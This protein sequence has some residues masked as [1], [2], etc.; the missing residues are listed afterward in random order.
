MRISLYF[1]FLLLVLLPSCR[2]MMKGTI[3]KVPEPYVQLKDGKM[4]QASEVFDQ[5][6]IHKEGHIGKIP[7]ESTI[8]KPRLVAGDSAFK[9]HTVASFSDGWRSFANVGRNNFVFRMGDGKI[10]SYISLF[11]R[12]GEGHSEQTFQFSADFSGPGVKDF[13]CFQRPVS[14][15]AVIRP[16]ARFYV[17]SSNEGVVKKLNY[18]NLRKMI[19][20]TAVSYNYLNRYKWT[21]IITAIGAAGGL[22]LLIAGASYSSM[23]TNGPNPDQ[24]KATI[25]ST[26][27][28]AG[29]GICL[30]SLT[31]KWT[32][33]NNL[34]RAVEAYN[35]EP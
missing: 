22:S 16:H 17:Q 11:T 23:K 1:A 13:S 10:N 12:R 8:Y 31:M 35:I 5:E 15:G 28:V 9:W 4:V 7:V 18:S 3:A 26:T 29:L 19:P 24:G 20:E 27:A 33:R 32:N 25:G 6:Y 34:V 2:I 30:S 14:H 21:R